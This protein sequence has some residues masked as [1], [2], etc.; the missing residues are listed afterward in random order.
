MVSLNIL[1][2]MLLFHGPDMQVPV[3]PLDLSLNG[4]QKSILSVDQLL[5]SDLIFIR[6]LRENTVFGIDERGTVLME[7]K[8]GRQED[9]GGNK[10]SGVW[11][12]ARW[13]NEL[14]GIN[15]N[16]RVFCFEGPE[17][18]HAFPVG[19]K[20]DNP[21]LSANAFAVSENHV[22]VPV[23]LHRS[24][25]A[26]IFDKA[27]QRIGN[28]GNTLPFEQE[29]LRFN[30]RMNAT[31]WTYQEGFFYALFLYYPMALK[32][33]EDFSETQQIPLT[34]QTFQDL[35]P[36]L[37][38]GN[39]PRLKQGPMFSDF[40]IRHNQLYLMCRGTLYTADLDS[41]VAKVKATFYIDR[42]EFGD[43]AGKPLNFPRF[44]ILSSG[45]ILLAHPGH[46]W[47]HPLWLA[48][49]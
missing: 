40:Q 6:S 46:L 45:R 12:L 9:S 22:V 30:P 1:C 27:G 25:L 26:V 8:S 48:Q 18:S 23:P 14:W 11:S 20:L 17:F 42:P 7:H 21:T 36:K 41:G 24:H 5:G 28:L 35:S 16:G 47:N 10:L 33:S 13:E 37:M 34:H 44:S 43:I 49:L 38:A 31:I 19:H 3:A 4:D 2:C 15:G 32:V 29:A 39:S